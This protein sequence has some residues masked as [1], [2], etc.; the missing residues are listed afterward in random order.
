MI[1]HCL[2]RMYFLRWL[3]PNITCSCGHSWRATGQ[4]V[5]KIQ[6]AVDNCID[7]KCYK[8]YWETK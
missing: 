1:R 4:D 3:G 2:G 5:K 6:A 7:Q 8:K